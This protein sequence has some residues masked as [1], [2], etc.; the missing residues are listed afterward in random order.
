MDMYFVIEIRHTSLYNAM[1]ILFRWKQISNMLGA[2]R[3]VFLGF[4]YPNNYSYNYPKHRIAMVIMKWFVNRQ[5]LGN[6]FVGKMYFLWSI[7]SKYRLT[8]KWRT[9]ERQTFGYD[10]RYACSQSHAYQVCVMCIWLI[11]HMTDQFSWSHWVSH[12]QIRLYML[13]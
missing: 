7:L 4:R 2:Q 1:G 11:L 13:L 12:I 3:A 8:C 9:T 6:I 5:Y 10:I